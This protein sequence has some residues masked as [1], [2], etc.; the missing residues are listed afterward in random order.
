M[1]G[2]SES[3]GT[4]NGNVTITAQWEAIQYTLLING[5]TIIYTIE[6]EIEIPNAIP[7]P[8]G[9]EFS[10]WEV[11]GSPTG[12]WVPGE[13]AQALKVYSSGE[14]YGDANFSAK[15]T[16]LNYTFTYDVQGGIEIPDKTYYSSVAQKLHG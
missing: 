7:A 4:M 2:S 3:V 15:N 9:Y 12:N 6:D 10:G 1:Y 5:Q 16:A 13:I 11:Y 14:K 8:F